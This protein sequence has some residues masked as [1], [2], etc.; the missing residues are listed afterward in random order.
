MNPE[1]RIWWKTEKRYLTE[2]ELIKTHLCY[3]GT[4]DQEQCS[5][6]DDCSN[7]D[8]TAEVVVELYAGIKTE[9]VEDGQIGE[10][11]YAGDKVKMHQFLFDGCEEVE[12]EVCGIIGFNGITFTLTKIKSEWMERESYLSDEEDF[13]IP[14]GDFFGVH[15]DSWTKIGNVHDKEADGE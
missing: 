3:D 7:I 11:L 12:N 9:E 13:A 8:I 15:E 10:K 1:Y 5:P 14:I 2:H 4:V 6:L